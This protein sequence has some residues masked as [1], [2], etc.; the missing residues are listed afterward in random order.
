MQVARK[1]RLFLGGFFVLFDSREYYFAMYGRSPIK[2]ARLIAVVILRWFPAESPV[3]RPERIL[4]VVP[5]NFLR[6]SRSL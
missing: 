1:N 5:T 3:R 4:P 2:R 6:I